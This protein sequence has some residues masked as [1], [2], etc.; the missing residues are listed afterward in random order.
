MEEIYR[1]DAKQLLEYMKDL[2][3]LLEGGTFTEQKI[4]LRAFIKGIDF[5][6]NQVIISYTI[7]MLVGAR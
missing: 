7:P 1:L 5:K 6:P 4:F 3:A 2:K